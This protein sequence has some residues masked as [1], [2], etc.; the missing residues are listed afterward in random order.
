MKMLIDINSGAGYES[1]EDMRKDL[2]NIV[3]GLDAAA[4]YIKIL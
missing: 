4:V 1:E 2:I 3:E